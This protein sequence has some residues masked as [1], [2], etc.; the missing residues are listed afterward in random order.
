MHKA[1]HKKTGVAFALKD[2]SVIDIHKRDQIVKELQALLT[3]RN[4]WLV[5]FYGAF[6][7]EGCISLALEYMD[8]GSL[9]DI[10]AEMGSIP[11]PVLAIVIY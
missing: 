6:Y 8:G 3:A 1:I 5:G 4:P 9:A 10:L 2:I 11:E 7:S